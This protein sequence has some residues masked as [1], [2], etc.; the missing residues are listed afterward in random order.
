[1]SE[2][3]PQGFQ[4]ITADDFSISA[5]VGGWRGVVEATGPIILFVAIFTMTKRLIPALIGAVVVVVVSL[6]AQLL[7]RKSLEQVGI[8]ALWTLVGAV[9]ALASGNAVDFFAFGLI[10]DVVYVV[11]FG[12]SVVIGHN[13][14]GWAIVFVRHLPTTWRTDYPDFVRRSRLATLVWTGVF[15]IRLIIEVPLFATQ[16]VTALG[17]A[18]LVLGVPLFAL[19]VYWSW[20]VLTGHVPSPARA[21]DEGA[22]NDEPAA[23]DDRPTEVSAPRT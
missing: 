17:T 22:Q 4:A 6:V 18:K 3:R 5:V 20:V 9:W 14:I 21:D 23:E 12:L 15:L 16:A 11:V 10:L 2:R 19:A 7:T 1:M 13:L 8:G